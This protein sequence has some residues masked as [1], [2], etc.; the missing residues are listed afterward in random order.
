MPINKRR[1]TSYK[2]VSHLLTMELLSL[3][4]PINYLDPDPG[5]SYADRPKTK[6]SGLTTSRISS[7][8]WFNAHRGSR[9]LA[10]I[11]GFCSRSSGS[12]PSQNLWRFVTSRPNHTHQRDYTIRALNMLNF[13]LMPFYIPLFFYKRFLHYF[14]ILIS[15]VYIIFY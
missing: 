14:F 7:W 11:H 1:L 2:F 12:S 15:S 9:A 4:F 13:I 3:A 10:H 5:Q 6:A 8:L